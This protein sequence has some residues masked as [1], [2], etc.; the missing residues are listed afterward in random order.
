MNNRE[1]G[2]ISKKR[3][4][5]SISV[6]THEAQYILIATLQQ[7]FEN[8]NSD[9]R[10]MSKLAVM[11]NLLVESPNVILDG[12]SMRALFALTF[13]VYLKRCFLEGDSSE[14]LMR[15]KFCTVENFLIILLT[16]G[17]SNHMTGRSAKQ[18]SSTPKSGY[19]TTGVDR[20][21]GRRDTF[22]SV[23]ASMALKKTHLQLTMADTQYFSV[24]VSMRPR[25]A[26]SDEPLP[27][28]DPETEDNE[29]VAKQMTFIVDQAELFHARVAKLQQSDINLDDQNTIESLVP[30]F[31]LPIAGENTTQIYRTAIKVD[32][33]NE[34]SHR[35]GIY[36]W[37][38]ECRKTADFY[39]RD[40]RV[41]VCSKECK[42]NICRFIQGAKVVD[43]AMEDTIQTVGISE[44]NSDIQADSI[45][46]VVSYVIDITLLEIKAPQQS[47]MVMGSLADCLMIILE[48]VADKIEHLGEFIQYL[49]LRIV[50][51]VG[52]FLL[53]STLR[54]VRKASDLTLLL[55][56]H[57]RGYLKRALYALLD[58][59]IIRSMSSAYI[60]DDRSHILYDLTFSILNDRQL[61]CDIYTNYDCHSC[62]RS[63][64][65]RLVSVVCMYM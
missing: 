33:V 56:K 25:V 27:M 53:L 5:P 15:E 51:I 35:A 42:I 50:R 11:L 46:A 43:S 57:Y 14:S 13:K 47:D 9:G 31:V 55:F 40:T 62:Y 21:S 58:S 2:H 20:I 30:I 7:L 52:S 61:V 38:Y 49:E 17:S 32:I 59:I 36:G 24:D 63:V 48:K 60:A 41:P 22:N 29:I 6:E 3:E 65:H 37:C 26:K 64:L 19:L 23:T 39:C 10:L 12:A 34:K 45:L 16:K 18:T 8:L 1:T 28:D 54:L 4:S 44:A